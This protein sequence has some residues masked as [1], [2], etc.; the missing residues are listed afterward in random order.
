MFGDGDGDSA[1]NK[2]EVMS[3]LTE[4]P[5]ALRDEGEKGHKGKRDENGML[6]LDDDGQPVDPDRAAR[7]AWPEDTYVLVKPH[8]TGH[9]VNEIQRITQKI[10]IAGKA[11]SPED[12]DIRSELLIYL[13]QLVRLAVLGRGFKCP[14]RT[15]E[16]CLEQCGGDKAKARELF[17][18]S[19]VFEDPFTCDTYKEDGKNVL[20]MPHRPGDPVGG[21]GQILAWPD[22]DTERLKTAGRLPI[23]VLYWVHEEIER[24]AGIPL[25]GTKPVSKSTGK[26]LSGRWWSL[27]DHELQPKRH[28]LGAKT[29]E[30]DEEDPWESRRDELSDDATKIVETP[31][32]DAF[33]WRDPLKEAREQLLGEEGHPH[34]T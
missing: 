5:I 34:P 26:G 2:G 4:T 14:I 25:S 28:W 18:A 24:L 8:V 1:M 3:W 17:E 12:L 33:E 32:G 7:P 31:F 9:D 21:T 13:P 30:A 29:T 16:K 27:L 22:T 10:E 19:N 6:V 15:A 11:S 23:E 20:D